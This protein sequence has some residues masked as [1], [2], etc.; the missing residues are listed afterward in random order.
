MKKV[1]LLS[2]FISQVIFFILMPVWLELTNHLHPLVV[3]IVW[4]V[5]FFLTLF[6]VC[7]LLNERVY[8]SQSVLRGLIFFYTI[9]LLILLF[10]R[11]NGTNYGAVNMMPFMTIRLYLFGNADFLI[12]FYNLGANIGLFIPFGVYYGFINK[13]AS[14]KQLLFL[15]IFPIC[16]IEGL[17]FLTK[18]GSLDIDDLLLNTVGVCL[19]Y[20]L[21]PLFRKV[22]LIK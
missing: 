21:L 15:T 12:A 9:G 6:I 13:S 19:G 14:T 5:I 11:P 3:G 18:R 8:V 2:V 16:I 4:F 1:I 22:L 17:Q 20:Y 10:F 7:L